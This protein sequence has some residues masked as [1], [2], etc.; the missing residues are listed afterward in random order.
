MEHIY[1]Y[2][3][4]WNVSNICL[5]IWEARS[6]TSQYTDQYTFSM[7]LQCVNFCFILTNS[8]VIQ[9]FYVPYIT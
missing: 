2:H 9:N 4:P 1:Q 8:N 7:I 5:H 6:E 3:L